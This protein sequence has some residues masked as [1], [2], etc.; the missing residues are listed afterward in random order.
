M[1][2]YSPAYTDVRKLLNLFVISIFWTAAAHFPKDELES[3]LEDLFAKLQSM[4]LA[5]SV[6]IILGRTCGRKALVSI[7]EL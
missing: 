4:I 7:S 5:V 1:R 3:T 6:K 2:N